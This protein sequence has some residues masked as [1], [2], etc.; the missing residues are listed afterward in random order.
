M[1]LA[2]QILY[3]EQF[4]VPCYDI[5]CRYIL[6]GTACTWPCTVHILH[7]EQFLVP[8]YDI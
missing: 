1:Y 8:C 7:P 4:L 2:L 3:P 6:G 5:Y